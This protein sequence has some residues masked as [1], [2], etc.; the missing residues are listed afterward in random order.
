MNVDNLKASP[1]SPSRE[2]GLFTDQVPWY[3]WH[4]LEYGLSSNRKLRR[5]KSFTPR[6]FTCSQSKYSEKKTIEVR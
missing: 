5:C 1:K 2:T 6:F 4:L 3:E